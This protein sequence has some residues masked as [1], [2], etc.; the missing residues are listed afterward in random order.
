M[1]GN[2]E[3]EN[4]NDVMSFSQYLGIHKQGCDIEL[5]RINWSNFQG[6]RLPTTYAH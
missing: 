4:I 2:K 1:L 3:N 5:V 6:T